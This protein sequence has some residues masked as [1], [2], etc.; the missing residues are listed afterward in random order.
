MPGSAADVRTTSRPCS[1]R[2]TRIWTPRIGCGWRTTNG[3]CGVKAYWRINTPPYTPIQTL[4][5]AKSSLDDIRVLAGPTPQRLRPLAGR[6]SR[7]SGRL[8]LVKAPLELQAVHAVLRSAYQLAENAVQL[9]LEAVTAADVELAKQA[10]AAASGALMLLDRGLADLD[11]RAAPTGP[12]RPRV[13]AVITPR[14]TA[15]FRVPDLAAF[16]STIADWILDLT[17]EEVSDTFVLV[18]TRAAAEQLRRTVEDRGLRDARTAL[19]WPM[20]R[21]RR[22]FYEELASRLAAPPDMLSSIEREVILSA[23]SR[24][25]AER[26]LAPPFP[27]RP[28][29]VA[30]M[31]AFYDQVRR[32]G[33]TVE[34][35]ERNFQDELEREQDTDR[36]AARLLQQTRF[37]AAAF[38]GYQARLRDA[39]RCDEHGLRARILSETFGRPL[40]RVVVTVADRLADPDG[41]WPADFDVLTRLPGLERLDLVCTEAVLAAGYLER[42]HAALPDLEDVRS[43]HLARTPP[44]LIARAGLAGLADASVVTH[45][46]REEELAAVARRLKV[47]RQRSSAAPLHRTALV[48]RRPLPYLYLARDVFADAAIPFETLDTLPLA[49]EPYA[50]AV[51]LALDAVA[52]DFTRTS[53]LALLRSPHFAIHDNDRAPGCG[54]AECSPR[55]MRV[56]PG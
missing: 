22:D 10:S 18:P 20:V 56:R 30:E 1:P 50:A 33:R 29:L 31:L 15:L 4:A 5:Q 9:R 52:S 19:S 44:T 3:A 32:L 17:T 47:E 42:L 51:D 34:D 37:L 21:P 16:R 24:E 40:R 14:R 12:G 41:L 2:S 38:R 35:F 6:L 11:A 7:A 39:D 53:L 25:V 45:R 49:A 13:A 26:G 46:D 23:V 27:L 28:G 8:A 43:R 36:G 48:V 55:G 54:G